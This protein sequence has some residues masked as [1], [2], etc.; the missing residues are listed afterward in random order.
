VR[1]VRPG[2]LLAAALVAAA[3]SLLVVSSPGRAVQQVRVDGEVED[4]PLYD[5]VDV[6]PAQAGA[7]PV[8]VD[9]W[10]N[11][12]EGGV[13]RPGE[14]MRIFFRTRADAYVLVYNIDTEGYIHLVF[15]YGPSDPMRVEGGKTYRIPARHDPYDLVADGPP[16]MEFVVA[17]ASKSPF[18]DLP[19]Y[20]RGGDPDEAASDDELES[21]QVV[22]DP[23]VGMERLNQRI[24]APEHA[25]ESDITETWFYIEK[26]VDY[27]RYVCA[28]CHY[29]A[30][31]FD[32]YL[33]H[34]SVV[35]VRIDATWVRYARPR[36]GVVRPRYYYYVRQGA[37]DRYR[38]WKDRRWSSLDGSS[39]LRNRFVVE[40]SE[41]MVRERQ[42]TQKRQLPPE[43][44]DLRRP[45]PGRL[46]QGRD[47]IIRLREKVPDVGRQR[48]GKGARSKEGDSP[49]VTPPAT[50]ERGKPPATHESDR[51]E[52]D[53]ERGSDPRD[54]RPNDNPR[55]R[56]E[57]KRGREDSG[58]DR[59]T[60]TRKREDSERVPD[61]GQDRRDPERDSGR[62]HARGRARG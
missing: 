51:R 60:E 61:K 7:S 9:V 55:P 38:E 28:D 18:R 5:P 19:W 48:D 29:A 46:W 30:Y 45:R 14:S 47:E 41:R 37:P 17:V 36:V 54:K 34:C 24:I 25:D 20:L 39:T 58:R 2:T 31:P 1:S 8:A 33:S 57:E 56:E 16:G 53:R 12:E 6:V 49:R 40:R 43:F 35:D 15:P 26:R 21:G 4:A 42:S 27:P 50:R 52:S 11:R 10:V 59:G 23:Y 22:G 13:Y 44:Q 3:F 32:P 62:D